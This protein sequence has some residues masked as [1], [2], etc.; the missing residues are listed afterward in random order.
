MQAANPLEKRH[1][2]SWWLVLGEVLLLGALSFLGAW[3]LFSLLPISIALIVSTTSILTFPF[4]R[5][6]LTAEVHFLMTIT[7]WGSLCA[8]AILL[9][10]R[11]GEKPFQWLIE[12]Y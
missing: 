12:W 6:R 7:A 10:H 8:L 1:R 4:L 3:L 9:I 5:H 11:F 2:L